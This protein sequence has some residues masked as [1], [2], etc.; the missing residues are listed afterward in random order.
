MRLYK[1][2]LK[3]TK[4]IIRKIFALLINS[5]RRFCR[6]SNANYSA[7]D[8]H[9]LVSTACFVK[10]GKLETGLNEYNWIHLYV[11]FSSKFNSGYIA[12]EGTQTY[13]TYSAIME[14]QRNGLLEV[15]PFSSC[16]CQ[17]FSHL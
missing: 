9:I 5:A 17:D 16:H 13:I 12:S 3:N 1:T 8:M 14:I 7:Q 11:C 6:E 2:W 4:Y 15:K 10:C